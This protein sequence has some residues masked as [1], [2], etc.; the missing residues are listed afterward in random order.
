MVLYRWANIALKR[1][2]F[3]LP[4][5]VAE[6]QLVGWQ[7]MV[8]NSQ[9][10]FFITAT[11]LSGRWLYQGPWASPYIYILSHFE[12]FTFYIY[13]LGDFVDLFCHLSGRAVSRPTLLVSNM[14]FI[15][16]GSQWKTCAWRSPFWVSTLWL[17]FLQPLPSVYYFTT[18]RTIE[19]TSGNK[20]VSCQKP[21]PL[22][23]QPCTLSALKETAG[24][25]L[26]DKLTPFLHLQQPC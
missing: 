22:L 2:W 12:Y 8:V 6:R 17:L 11:P 5:L 20:A 23:T 26:P 19:S 10:A 15:I 16:S 3:D 21:A 9:T 4:P 25:L 1:F 24:S 14:T 7:R 13:C 18:Y